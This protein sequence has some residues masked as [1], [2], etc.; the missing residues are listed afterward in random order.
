MCAMRRDKRDDPAAKKRPADGDVLHDTLHTIDGEDLRSYR[1][2]A[3]SAWPVPFAA[4][5]W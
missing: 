5:S 2:R 3:R 4:P 1:D